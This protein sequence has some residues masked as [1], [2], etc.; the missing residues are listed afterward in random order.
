M[1]WVS[2]KAQA[3]CSGENLIASLSSFRVHVVISHI[4]KFQISTAIN[5]SSHVLLGL[6]FVHNVTLCS[7]DTT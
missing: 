5:S 4:Q 1:S 2:A 3:S 7:N 6:K